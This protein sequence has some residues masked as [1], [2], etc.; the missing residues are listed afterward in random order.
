MYLMFVF[1][2]HVFKND[3]ASFVKFSQLFY[4]LESSIMLRVI[5][6]KKR[7]CTVFILAEVS[8]LMVQGDAAQI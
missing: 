4:S 1:W 7:V 8:R 5:F 6:Q 3:V 2:H